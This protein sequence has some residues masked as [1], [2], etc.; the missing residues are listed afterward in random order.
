MIDIIMV[1]NIK[2]ITFIIIIVFMTIYHVNII[3]L[4][5]LWNNNAG[6]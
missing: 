3:I 6:I 5:E 4:I 1:I 2:L